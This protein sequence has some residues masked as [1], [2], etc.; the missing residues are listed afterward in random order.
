MLIDTLAA[1][2]PT[3]PALAMVFVGI[4]VEKYYVSRVTVFTNAIALYVSLL[5]VENIPRLMAWYVDFAL[6]LGAYG[7]A[8]YLLNKKTVWGYNAA[9]FLLYASL[10]VGAVVIVSPE[11]WLPAL[12]LAGVVNAG[13]GLWLEEKSVRL[14]HWGPRPG[15]VARFVRTTTLEFVDPF[16]VHQRAD[17]NCGRLTRR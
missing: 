3:L 7:M 14:A 2:G 15:P 4:A 6:V 1:A 8:A 5:G 12:L 10:P 13:A 11:Y 9:A 16:G 17:L